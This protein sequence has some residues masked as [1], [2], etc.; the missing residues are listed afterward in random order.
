MAEKNS[1]NTFGTWQ[2]MQFAEQKMEIGVI[3]ALNMLQDAQP[4]DSATPPR[5]IPTFDEI[6]EAFF[7][8]E[9]PEAEASF[10]QLPAFLDV[11]V[12]DMPESKAGQPQTK[13]Q[14]IRKIMS[15][16][17]FYGFIICLLCGA[18]LIS[19]GNKKTVLG[20]SFMSVLTWSMQSEIPQGSMVI[21]KQV[22]ANTLQVGD[23]ITYM[24]DAHTSVTHRVISITEN[25][26]ETGARGFTTQGIEND[27]PDFEIV[28]AVN[29]VG[30][31][32]FH[33]PRLG[34]WLTWLREH[35]M[36][37]LLFTAGCILFVL[38][39][40]GALQKSPTEQEKPAHRMRQT[41]A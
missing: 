35:L 21:I 3:N 22:D 18:F 15:A 24:K 38:L 4:V 20:Y 7:Q 28:P 37:M 34:E 25:Y 39:L 14:K 6:S 23:D 1:L 36:I 19:Q 11:R 31:V 5:H 17:T 16:V 26:E 41:A 30:K 8:N 9:A 13:W 12:F 27:T 10:G 33:I 2:E 40:K 32:V 29:V